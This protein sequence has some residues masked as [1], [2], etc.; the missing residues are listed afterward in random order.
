MFCYADS[1]GAGLRPALALYIL[2]PYCFRLASTQRL[3]VSIQTFSGNLHMVESSRDSWRKG[4]ATVVITNGTT[5]RMVASPSEHEVWFQAPDIPAI[6]WNNPS[7][8]RYTAQ[9][10]YANQSIDFDWLL[11]GDDDTIFLMDNVVDLVRDLDP[12]EPYFMTDAL[13]P[14]GL[15]CTLR[16]EASEIGPLNCI[17]TPSAV[18]CTRAVLE[19]ASVCHAEN[20]AHRE[21]HIDLPPG[22]IWGLGQYGMLVS[23]GLLRSISEADMLGCEYCNI[24]DFC[25]GA[26][27]KLGVCNGGGCY[28]GGD[29]RLGECFWRFAANRAGIGPTVPYSHKDVKVFGHHLGDILGHAE[30]VIRGGACDVSCHFV[31]D[32]VISTDLHHATPEEYRK[33]TH[34]FSAKYAHAK[35]LLHGHHAAAIKPVDPVAATA[36]GAVSAGSSQSAALTSTIP[37]AG[38]SSLVPNSTSEADNTIYSATAPKRRLLIAGATWSGG[39]HLVHASKRWREPVNSFLVTNS[40]FSTNGSTYKLLRD[41]RFPE[42]G[43]REVWAEFPDHIDPRCAGCAGEATHG[44]PA[45]PAPANCGWCG[46]TGN[47]CRY[48]EQRYVVTPSLA[49]QTFFP[50]YDWLLYADAETIW[51]AE[52]VLEMLASVDPNEPWYFSESMFPISNNNC[53]FPG[54]QPVMKD[55]CTYSPA[56]NPLCSHKT[57]L[58]DPTTCAFAVAP[59]KDLSAVRHPRPA[60]Q[61][62]NGGNWGLIVS[63]GL[64]ASI[65]V[66]E[67][68]DCALCRN[69][70]ACYGG[71]DCRI[72]ECIWRYGTGPT[73]PDRNYSEPGIRQYRLGELNS[74][75]YVSTLK[76]YAAKN[77]CD[78]E[79]K[80]DM[81]HPLALNIHSASQFL[82]LETAYKTLEPLVRRR[83]Y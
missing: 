30:Q 6:G 50:N 20:P 60:G 15:S 72:G 9:V 75:A 22:S 68:L 65:S 62:W 29:V 43:T 57:F 24:T 42:H 54:Q 51:F 4:V 11:A 40:S 1:R 63:R 21:G 67:W 45:C 61:V 13:L 48:H 2:V 70:A 77:A 23:R 52:N 33:M 78:G 41:T 46:Q 53:V 26:N 31:L 56:P 18:P 32:R 58:A 81:T 64:M 38:G 37:A 83:A 71:G 28:G 59:D 36:L 5:E 74:D 55:G 12:D 80:F 47:G 49:N 25:H 82:E 17:K 34:D 8:N 3:A 35:R 73:L 14:N 7:E 10:R 19:D 66:E 69:G 79:C 16:Q 39:H 27:E 44:T 76:G